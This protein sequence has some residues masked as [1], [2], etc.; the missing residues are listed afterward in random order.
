MTLASRLSSP[1]LKRRRFLAG[2]SALAL[3]P[4]LA[5][6][7]GGGDSSGGGPSIPGG[8]TVPPAPGVDGPAWWG[9][10]RDAQHSALSAIA[11]QDLN[12][13]A[14]AT[15]LDLDPQYRGGG[16][17][18]THYGSPVIT[19]HNTV[20]LP[21]KTGANGG[22]RIE[23]RSG[24]NGGPIWSATVD[25][26]LPPHNWIPSYN[27]ALTTGNRLYAPGAGGKLLV[28][29]DADSSSGSLQALVFFGAA[30]YAAA[31]ALYD[32]SVFI[33]T[34]ITVDAAGNVFFGFVVTAAN[35]AGLESGIARIGANGV[36]G[37]VSARIISEDSLVAKVQTNSAP[38]LSP[39]L[40][41]LYVA[42]NADPVSGRVQGGYLLA[43]DSSTLALKNRALLID[44]G[45]GDLARVSD[46][47]TAS[48]TVGP[49]GDVYFGVLE[50]TFGTHNGR[51]WLLHYNATLTTLRLPGGFGWD[52]T[53]SVVP[54]TAVPGY[55]GGSPYLLML[56]Y[57]NYL[58]AGS[59]DGANRIAIVDPRA[60]Q[61]DSI[62]GRPIMKEVLTLLGP[63]FESGNS[64][65]VVEWC[66][67]TA[68]VDPFTRSVLVNS[69]DGYLYRWD[70]T[71]NSASQRIRLTSGIGESYTPT[72]IGAD[73]AVYAVNNAVLFSI[74][75]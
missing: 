13:I 55:A 39:D 11:T 56:K 31:P 63:T 1:A 5:G 35:P 25:Y 72:A 46:D 33:N 49:D 10:A 41:T 61:V 75:R 2:A 62:S 50:T 32:A 20:V 60:S 27:L 47:S 71:S 37:W 3:A 45:S 57:N 74:A 44:P 16:A 36:G 53:A 42:V 54:A 43:L 30:A 40:G 9:F 23:A 64:G 73:G 29:A 58:G 17:L 28:K 26:V 14:W 52:D 15:P 6:C 12:R 59:G 65:P 24:V 34:P 68:A 7:G 22:F 4:V 21:V 48:P 38:A 66:I 70:L 67:N 8:P 19:S 69:E 51:G 18:L